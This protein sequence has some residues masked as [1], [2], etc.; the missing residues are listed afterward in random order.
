MAS[1]TVMISNRTATVVSVSANSLSVKLP[2]LPASESS[3]DG[4][5]RKFELEYGSYSFEVSFFQFFPNPVITDYNP[6]NSLLDGNTTIFIEGTNLNR[7]GKP[8][9]TV[10]DVPCIVTTAGDTLVKCQTGKSTGASSGSIVLKLGEAVAVAPG[11][12]EYVQSQGLPDWVIPVVVVVSVLV[13][14]GNVSFNHVFISRTALSHCHS[15]FFLITAL[16]VGFV[17]YRR[18]AKKGRKKAALLFAEL[19]KANGSCLTLF[20]QMND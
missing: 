9:V 2:T 12:F 7:G 18:Q 10:N 19:D 1:P 3:E 6:K 11:N 20:S 13:L 5:F 16:I 8:N 4:S 15:L 14:V 17:L